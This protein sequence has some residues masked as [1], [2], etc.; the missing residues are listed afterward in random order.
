M[1]FGNT[2]ANGYN[3]HTDYINLLQTQTDL[4]AMGTPVSTIGP[5]QIQATKPT[6][7]WQTAKSTLSEQ[8]SKYPDPMVG[9]IPGFQAR[10]S[11]IAQHELDTVKWEK[12][13]KNKKK[14]SSS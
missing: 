10:M 3:Y 11:E 5:K 2:F 12:A 8:G 14:S 13:K 7:R 4:V 6:P 1:T 9:C